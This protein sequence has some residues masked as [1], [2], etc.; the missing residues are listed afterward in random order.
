MFKFNM[1]Y[2]EICLLVSYRPL[3]L[4]IPGLHHS[5]DK[6]VVANPHP[7]AFAYNALSSAEPHD[8]LASRKPPIS[9]ETEVQ[10][11]L[12]NGGVAR[13]YAPRSRRESRPHYHT[14]LTMRVVA[15]ILALAAGTSGC[16]CTTNETPEQ[17]ANTC[18][19]CVWVDSCGIRRRNLRFGAAETGCCTYSRDRRLTA[20][21][22]TALTAEEQEHRRLFCP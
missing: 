2:I 13:S 10:E 18:E 8:S 1:M 20:E 16:P 7:R 3:A 17:C 4:K 14:G 6:K 12:E 5:L 15:V 21:E 9:E 19:G 22:T 11:A